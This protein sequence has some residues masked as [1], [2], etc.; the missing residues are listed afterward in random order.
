MEEEGRGLWVQ[1]FLLGP[2]LVVVFLVWC[3][4]GLSVGGRVPVMVWRVHD[5]LVWSAGVVV[6][7]D[8]WVSL[9]ACDQ[10]VCIIMRVFAIKPCCILCEWDRSR[11]VVLP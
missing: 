4:A 1:I 8:T 11:S 3:S 6:V 9:L 7:L 2:V 10:G 5:W